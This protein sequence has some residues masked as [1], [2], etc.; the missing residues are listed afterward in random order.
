MGR[1]LEANLAQSKDMLAEVV[2][3]VRPLREGWA[4]IL[5]KT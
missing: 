3:V 1:L 4:E 2:R 5:E